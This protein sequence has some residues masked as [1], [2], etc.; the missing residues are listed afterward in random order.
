MEYDLR[1]QD[2]YAALILGAVSLLVIVESWRMPRHLQSWP[3]YAGP[4][5]VTGA[6]GLVLLGMAI[7]LFV[8]AWRRR[9]ALIAMPLPEIRRHLA[10]A[11]TRRLWLIGLLGTAYLLSLGRGLPY[12]L[13]T[14]A[15]LVVAML[16]F[17]AA[18]WWVVLLVSAGVTAA[19]A[20]VFNRVFLIPLP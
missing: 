11:R 1:R 7:G 3:A 8:R 4:G 2:L 14:G 16:L 13:T 17:R 12:Q 9:G 19:I 15:Y 20:F 10:D 18:R 6:L 5:V